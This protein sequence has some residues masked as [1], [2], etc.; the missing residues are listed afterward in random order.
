MLNEQLQKSN[1]ELPN[2]RKVVDNLTGDEVKTAAAR[3]EAE[4]SLN[5]FGIIDHRREL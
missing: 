3:R 2:L 4:I 1:L 5:P